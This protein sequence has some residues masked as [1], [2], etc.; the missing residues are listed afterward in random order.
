[1]RPRVTIRD[2]ALRANVHFTTVS[3]ALRN[4]PRIG[5]ATRARIKKIAEEM[6]YRP[7]AM[8]SA[9]SSYRASQKTPR[10]Q[11]TLAWINNHPVREQ[12][13][14]IGLYNDYFEGAKARAAQL[15]F[16]LEEIW[17][18]EPGLTRARV[19]TIL[20]TRDIRGVLVAPLPVYSSIDL[21]PWEQLAAVSLSYSLRNPKIHTVVPGQ[22]H[23]MSTTLKELRKLGYRRIG[24]ACDREFD[25]RCD[26]N[27]QAAFWVDYHAQPLE[28]RVEPLWYGTEPLSE[29]AFRAWFKSQRPEV[30]VPSGYMVAELIRRMGLKVPEDVGLAQHNVPHDDT[31]NSGITESGF[32]IGAAAVE[33]LLA[34]LGREEYGVPDMPQQQTVEGCWAPGKTVR[35]VR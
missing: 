18:R 34:L 27:W 28:S 2:I 14:A 31:V 13:Y 32:R 22:Y 5:E 26:N 8:L 30:L 10:Y 35:K 33:Y 7:D 12:L 20:R 3:M 16:E 17:L 25:L 29:K 24:F 9:L 21:L 4:N 15:G 1:M 6:G 11:A 19:G 23:A